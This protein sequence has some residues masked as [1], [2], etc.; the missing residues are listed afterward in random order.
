MIQLTYKY[1]DSKNRQLID[2]RCISFDAVISALNDGHLLD[3][4][5]HP[6]SNKYPI[7]EDICGGNKWL[8][9]FGSVRKRR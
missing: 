7:S 3:I 6:N 2:E 9:I 4:V 8:C 5:E 1:S